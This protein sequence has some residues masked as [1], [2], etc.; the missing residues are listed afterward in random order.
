MG[1]FMTNGSRR[2]FLT[3]SLK[4]ISGSFL[5]SSSSAYAVAHKH[6]HHHHSGDEGDGVKISTSLVNTCGTCRYWGGMRKVSKDKQTIA[7]QSMGWCNNPQSMHYQ[8]ITEHD[9]VMMKTQYWEKWS[10]L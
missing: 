4:L 6:E 9:H 5:L 8:T 2:N 3:S 10:V 7:I 1:E